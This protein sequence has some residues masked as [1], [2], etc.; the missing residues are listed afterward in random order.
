[1]TTLRARASVRWWTLAVVSVATFMLMLDLS[2]V[3]IALPGIHR[4]LH[5]DFGALQW[6]FDAYAL[7]LAVMLVTAGSVADRNGRK[8]LFV[9]GLGIFTAASLACGMSGT[10][11]LLNISRG[12]QG[13]G[14]A[15][16]FAVGPAL[17]GH[18]FHGKERAVAFGTFGASAGLA[19]ASGPL[20][21]GALVDGP[22]WRWI[23]F[24][25]VPVGLATVAV[26][27]LRL[28]ESRLRSAHRPDFVG[29]ITFTVALGALVL[30][31]IRG[32]ANGWTS[33]T[34]V[35]LYV[36]S[37]VFMLAF[38][39]VE[40]A[41]RERAM[42]DLSLFGNVTFVGLAVVT[43]VAN[44]AG[45]PSIFIE[46][47]FM[48][49]LLHFSPWDAGLRFL[50]LTL[51]LFV[52]GAVTGALTG[53]IPFRVLMALACAAIGVGLLLTQLA[54]ADS[55]WTAL[56]PSLIVT[57]AGMGMFNPTRAALAIGIAEPARAGVASGINETFQQV[58]MALGIAAIGAFFEHQVT[59]QFVA[60]GA[61]AHLGSGA[62][63]AASAIS[64]GALDATANSTGALHD[65]VLAA[66]HDSF[67]AGFH[68]AMMLCAVLALFAAVVAIG[69]LRTK[70]L[71]A[72]ALT[73]I[74]PELPDSALDDREAALPEFVL[75]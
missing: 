6:V 67:A 13:I 21:G 69:F 60:S 47:S 22:G 48:Q 5:A 71:H 43:F 65:S 73:G 59:T 57:G 58:G 52:F 36:V 40:R 3:A 7:T 62:H 34:N 72:S 39:L 45:L 66:A 54:G 20:I 31:I 46:T 42:F 1:M 30:A 56:I 23:F 25:N 14:A 38:V 11:E 10:I 8:R 75:L 37:G 70:D 12:V 16:L 26:A 27:R 53:K 18:E 28:R 33:A 64:A 19:V 17:I 32:G 2:V 50:P 15:I 35:S 41:L 51:A 55:P 44:G 24:V 9:V 68:D 29:M 74:P 49:N 4:S 63:S 61:G